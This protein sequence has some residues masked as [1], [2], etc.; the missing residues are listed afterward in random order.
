MVRHSGLLSTELFRD[1]ARL[2]FGPLLSEE[3]CEGLGGNDAQSRSIQRIIVIV[4]S[5][6]MVVLLIDQQ[7]TNM[8]SDPTVQRETAMP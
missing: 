8:A 7:A 3:V 6:G 2:S 1:Q 4:V 5:L